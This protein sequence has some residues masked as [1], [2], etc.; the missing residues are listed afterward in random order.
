ML[1]YAACCQVATS[2][3]QWDKALE[4]LQH[5]FTF[6]QPLQVCWGITR[7]THTHEHTDSFTHFN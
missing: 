2:K 5:A 6:A 7:T 3:G 1:T 4:M